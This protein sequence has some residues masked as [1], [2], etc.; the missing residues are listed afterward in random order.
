MDEARRLTAPAGAL[1]VGGAYGAGLAT[2]LARFPDPVCVAVVAFVVAIWRPRA[3]VWPTMLA[4]AAGIVVGDA[5]R[6][7]ER[8]SCAAS[9]PLGEQ[10]F[11]LRALEPG[12]GSG[13]VM[14]LGQGCHGAVSARWP[15]TAEVPAGS[16]ARVRGRWLPRPR[17]LG[18]PHGLLLVRRVE[19]VRTGDG[20]VAASR[21]QVS[22]AIVAT[23]GRRA[24]MVEALLTG[25][26]GE[27][28]RELQ[29]AYAATGLV[30]L[31]AISGSHVA[32]IAGWLTLLG[33][34][35]GVAP[36]HAAPIA[37][38]VSAGYGA[39]LGWPAP[40]ARA[41][42]LVALLVVARRRQRHL[43]L[44]AVFGGCVLLVLLAQPRA[45]GDVG[46]WLSFAAIAG[47]T[48]ASRVATRW[49]WDHAAAQLLMASAGATLA[50][51]P[52]AAVMLGRVAPIGIILNLVAI[53]LSALAMPAAILALVVRPVL[54]E[55]SVAFAASATALLDLLD[56]TARW[57]ATLPGAATGPA[58]GSLA[59]AVPWIAA[60]VLAVWLVR[61]RTTAAVA[62]RRAAW[63]GAAVLWWPL[64][65]PSVP[66]SDGRL[67]LH[68]LDVGQGDAAAIRTPNGHWIVVDAGPAEP[69]RWDAGTRVVVPW[70]RR[71]GAI[72]IELLV[73]S[74]A[75]RDHVGGGA[76]VVAALPVR[77]A[78]DPGVPFD[79]AGYDAWLAGLAGQGTAWHRAAV[80]TRVTLDGVTLRV[81][82]AG[83]GWAGAGLDLNED[84]I[85]LEVSYGAFRALLTGDAGEVAE[86]SFLAR[87]G[88]VDLLKV[89]HHGSRTATGEALLAR[90]RPDVAVISSGTN[91]YGHPHPSVLGRLA[92]AGVEVWRT[93]RAGH[94]SVLTDGRTLTVRGGRSVAHHDVTDPDER[95]PGAPYH[96]GHDP[97]ALHPRPGARAPRRDRRAHQPPL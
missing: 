53:P 25:R 3:P 76:A 72:A 64:L 21:T 42:A 30:H 8:T 14:V 59:T 12:S 78:L 73:V 7:H 29:D 63:V 43:R 81:V 1:L 13:R 5:V 69:G 37:A 40:V 32:L 34:M 82:H 9:L 15:S 89:G 65:V 56:A 52:I 45:I 6:R 46:A 70:L 61:G 35:T 57:G 20:W 10:T 66:R 31:L 11:R 80:G 68:F 95:T 93:D 44:D 90:T 91:R 77:H 27:L 96:E 17:A 38:L 94:V 23:F 71:Q 47:T 97:R 16:E 36:S 58:V 86:A 88:A 28:D 24:P 85:V 87:L 62:G 49:G 4:L 39:W 84:S 55:L 26:R 92:A 79:E 41:V 2:G 74:H 60:L 54:P 19:R 75:H 51:A 18:A 50:T 22:G 48:W 33:T 67:A 83:T